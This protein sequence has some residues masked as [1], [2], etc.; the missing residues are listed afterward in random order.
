MIILC[1]LETMV[2]KTLLMSGTTFINGRNLDN[3]LKSKDITLL[4]KVRTGK[5]LVF[6]VV[7]CDSWTT[8]KT[9]HQRIDA[10]E[11]WC[12]RKLLRVPGTQ[13]DQTSQS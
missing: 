10:F 1:V 6:S 5:A 9:E 8:K 13:G 3:T 4:T 2:L 11:L 7:A 12:W